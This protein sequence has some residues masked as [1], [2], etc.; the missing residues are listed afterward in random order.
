MN[1]HGIAGSNGKIQGFVQSHLREWD[2][3]Y[4]VAATVGSWKDLLST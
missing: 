1:N 3:M 4:N 2:R